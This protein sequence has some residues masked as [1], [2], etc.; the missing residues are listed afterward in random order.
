MKKFFSKLA[1]YNKAIVGLVSFVAILLGPDTLNLVD[2]QAQLTQTILSILG[3][4]GI[5]AVP[6]KA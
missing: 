4:I 3:L 6:N 1:R 2:D 5:Y